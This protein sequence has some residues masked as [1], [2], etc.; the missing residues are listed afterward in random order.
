[1]SQLRPRPAPQGHSGGNLCRL[2]IRNLVEQLRREQLKLLL[3]RPPLLE[4][5][6]RDLA[7]SSSAT[8]FT[9]SEITSSS[10]ARHSAA[11]FSASSATTMSSR[12]EATSSTSSPRHSAAIF[13]ASSQTTSSSSASAASS[14]A[15]AFAKAHSIAVERLVAA[16]RLIRWAASH[17][18][19]SFINASWAARCAQP[20]RRHRQKAAAERL[21]LDC[22]E[23]IG[24]LQREQL[25]YGLAQ[26]MQAALGEALEVRVRQTRRAPAASSAPAP[27]AASRRMPRR[28]RLAACPARR[29]P[30][31]TPLTTSAAAS[32]PACW[33]C[34]GAARC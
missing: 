19:C 12:P 32:L 29:A 15:Y 11:T 4:A 17:S 7:A 9:R 30:C 16:R 25:Q 22:G 26:V 21:Q 1:M 5:L 28:R 18:A 6:F 8:V 20:S 27:P 3:L 13:S 24:L 23:L 34:E 10:S 33:L 31:R 2:L 14:S